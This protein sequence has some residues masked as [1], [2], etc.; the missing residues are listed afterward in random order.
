M[1]LQSLKE[2]L[3]EWRDYDAAAFALGSALGLW[4]SA[5]STFA[6]DVKHV[7]WS[8]HEVGDE[9]YSV[10]AS[11]SRLGI[12]LDDSENQRYRWNPEYRG[13]WER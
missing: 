13:S 1:P 2:A 8:R 6:V 9:L 7:L 11:L 5:F 10:L 4:D 12:L 3:Q